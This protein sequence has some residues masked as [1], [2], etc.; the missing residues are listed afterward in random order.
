MDLVI[1]E[2]NSRLINRRNVEEEYRFKLRQNPAKIT[3]DFP[4]SIGETFTSMFPFVRHFTF[5]QAFF[6][7]TSSNVYVLVISFSVNF[8]QPFP[9]SLVFFTLISFIPCIVPLNNSQYFLFI[10]PNNLLLLSFRS[11][12]IKSFHTLPS[13]L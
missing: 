6:N 1:I 8:I 11:I 2:G 4:L 10:F 13:T 9:S 5:V 12:S 3:A 7:F